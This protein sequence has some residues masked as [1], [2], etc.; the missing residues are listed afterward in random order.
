MAKM[1]LKAKVNDSKFQ[2]QV[3]VSVTSY[4]VDKVKFTDGQ[5]DGETRQTDAGNDNTTSAWK[6]EG[7]KN[8]RTVNWKL[9]IW[10]FFV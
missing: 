7:L 4:Y 3:R 2:Y 6:A 10:Q 1:T 8:T 5:T 9:K